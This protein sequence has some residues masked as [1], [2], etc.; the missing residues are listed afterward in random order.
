MNICLALLTFLFVLF[1]VKFFIEVEDT[2]RNMHSFVSTQ[3]MISFPSL[4]YTHVT[5]QHRGQETDNYQNPK[6]LLCPFLV[7]NHPSRVTSFMIFKAIDSFCLSQTLYRWNQTIHTLLF[8]SGV[9]H[10][11]VHVVACSCICSFSLLWVVSNL[12]LLQRMLLGTF[13]H[14]SVNEHMGT[15]PLGWILS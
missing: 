9:F 15:F 1:Y 4:I 14:M 3:S 13:L 10:F 7:P 6:Y 11:I 2:V 12:E 5:N 8:P